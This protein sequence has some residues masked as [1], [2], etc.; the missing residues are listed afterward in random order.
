MAERVRFHVVY[1][2]GTVSALLPLALSLL[3]EPGADF[4]LVDNGCEPAESE[5]IAQLAE[6]EDR[7]DWLRLPDEQPVRHGV[8]LDRL[9]RG[10]DREDGAGARFGILD[11]DVLASGPFLAGLSDALDQ[12]AG[13]ACSGWPVWLA[14]ADSVVSPDQT[15]LGGPYRVLADGTEVGG[16]SC[17][18]YDREALDRALEAIGCGLANRTREEL[19]PSLREG[20]VRHGWGFERFGTARIAHLQL[21]RQGDPIRNVE[22]DRLH[23][24]GGV[25]HTGDHG[26]RQAA[27]RLLRGPGPPTR[28]LL[29]N[30][31]R[32][33]RPSERARSLIYRRKERVLAEATAMLSELAAGRTAPAPVASG[34]A[35]VDARFG[36]L[37]ASFVRDY[38]GY[39]QRLAEIRG[40]L[41]VASRTAP[42]EQVSR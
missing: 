37:R 20:L 29:T 24:L 42:R 38:P 34:S 14:D 19:G 4:V 3:R 18:L 8:A 7:F 22:C 15:F 5:A 27:R 41:P 17:A 9:L 39:R 16:T 2:P 21:I 40:G 35:E 30:L 32:R 11:S 28:N 36:R 23:H 12:G 31:G 6:A 1:M 33:L 25:S 13:A 26:R 10:G